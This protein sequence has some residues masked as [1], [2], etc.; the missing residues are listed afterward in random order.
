MAYI[1]S[2]DFKE[3]LYSGECDYRATLIIN[4]NT[5]PN[6]QISSISISSPIVDDTNDMFY[7]GT[8]ISQKI[9]IKFNN[10]DGLSL[11]SGQNVSLSIGQYVNNAWVDVPIGLFIVDDLGENYQK[12]CEIT[13]MDYGVKFKPNI[14]YS[15][16]FVDGKATIDT[17]L[18][19]ICTQFGVTLGDYPTIN[20]DVEIGTYDSTISGKQWISYIAEIKGCNAKIDREGRLTLQPLKQASNQV[21]DATQNASFELGEKY[22]VSKVTYTDA[23]RNYTYG[24]D[25]G[26]TLFI[27]QDNPFVSDDVVKNIYL[28]VL[29]Q[30]ISETNTNINLEDMVNNMPLEISPIYGNT[31]QE[32]I[33]A[34]KNLLVIPSF[35]NYTSNGITFSYSKGVLTYSGTATSSTAYAGDKTSFVLPPNRYTFST[36]QI[37]DGVIPQFSLYSSNT[38]STLRKVNASTKR[39]TFTSTQPY[40]AIRL[41]LSGLTSG[42]TYSGTI[43]LQLEQNTTSTEWVEPQG[44]SPTPSEP[45]KIEVVSG[46]NEIDIVGA[47]ILSMENVGSTIKNGITYTITDNVVVLNG[48]STGTC[49]IGIDLL[50]PIPSGSV[51][52]YGANN[53]EIP[54][55][56]SV[57]IRPSYNNSA[58]ETLWVNSLN[59]TRANYT[60]PNDMNK[61]YVVVENNKT[62]NNF[63]LKLMANYGTI[64]IPYEPYTS[65]KYPLNLPVENLFKNQA[66]NTT[67]QGITFTNDIEKINIIGTSSSGFYPCIIMYADGSYI[68]SDW[69]AT[70]SNINSSKGYFNNN[71]IDNIFTIVNNGTSTTTSYRYIL[72][73]E[74]TIENNSQNINASSYKILN[75]NTER[76]NFI[77]IG[78][79]PSQTYNLEIKIQ[80]E[81]GTKKNSY[82]PYGVEPIELCKMGDYQD[83][84]GHIKGI[85]LFKTDYIVNGGVTINDSTNNYFTLTN[86]WADPFVSTTNTNTILKPNTKYTISCSFKCASR[87]SSF[88]VN[89][90]NRILSLYDGTH[91]YQLIHDD[92][93]NTGVLGIWYDYSYT[94]TTPSTLNN[95]SF[96]SYTYKDT[97]NTTTGSIE[98]TNLQ[99][100]EGTQTSDFEPYGNSSE[101]YLKKEIEKTELNGSESWCVANTNNYR[102]PLGINVSNINT[103][104]DKTLILSDHFLS[105]GSSEGDVDYQYTNSFRR[106]ES[107]I[108]IWFMLTK[109]FISSTTSDAILSEWE[110]WLGTNN[111]IV[112]YI[113]ANSRYTKITNQTLL[114][115]LNALEG[116]YSYDGTTNISTT[117]N[118]LLPS[119]SVK[120]IQK[121]NFEAYSLKTYGIGDFTLDAWD[122]MSYQVD[123][124]TYKTLNS[125]TITYSGSIMGNYETKIPTKQQEITTNVVEENIKSVKKFA[126]TEIDNVN[127]QISLKVGKDEVINSI[128]LST[129]GASIDANKISLN[130]KTINLTSDTI[131]IKS[132]NFDVDTEGNLTC[133]E[134]TMKGATF[135]GGDVTLY[136][137]IN[138]NYDYPLQIYAYNTITSVILNETYDL[139][140]LMFT[141]PSS[142][143]ISSLMVDFDTPFLR[144]ENDEIKIEYY[145]FHEVFLGDNDEQE[146][147]ERIL[148]KTTNLS[149]NS[150]KLIT[151]WDKLNDRVRI[152]KQPSDIFQTME[153]T[154]I[155]TSYSYVLNIT[156][157]ALT[158]TN[159]LTKLNANTIATKDIFLRDENQQYYFNGGGTSGT[160]NTNMLINN[161]SGGFRVTNDASFYD[162]NYRDIL[163]NKVLWDG[164]T[165]GYLML[166]SQTATLSESISN[167]PH[168]IVLVWSAYS[169]GVAQNYH[170]HC[171]FIPKEFI[172]LASSRGYTSIM[173]GSKFVNIA[174]KYVYINDT[175]ITGNADNNATGTASG[176]TYTNNAYVLRYVIGV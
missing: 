158:T 28:N 65:Q 24:D 165:T 54:P 17:I 36:D 104:V 159:G 95:Y 132:N 89:N 109:Y 103:R 105:N 69:W 62:L 20:G 64:A 172:N 18:Q 19:Y 52:S 102:Y 150:N 167:Q 119:L 12:T 154:L 161:L 7:V 49:Y 125:N 60:L 46:D 22:N 118:N 123:E 173:G 21:K 145:F 147:W 100:E 87:P 112:Y 88:G 106:G 163:A 110:T 39:I 47:N 122:N 27:R 168:G 151:L 155:D 79:S 82:T 78:L 44:A 35:S 141:Y 30:E 70:A 149:N 174:T 41:G 10:L 131:N 160:I 157:Y 50:K 97:N 113:L 171:D 33:E 137:D 73:K 133:N 134:A 38:S 51:I 176:I 40:Q 81:K 117:I 80:L 74:T 108:T 58:M 127:A 76:I 94:F 146:V 170:W 32:Q 53:I 11:E 114:S 13:C 128:N 148:E 45:S 144:F 57:S 42:N 140:K 43:K 90:Q 92:R 93:K 91:L 72:G 6:E 77:A 8:F 96:I 99:I 135:T 86:K 153:C 143:Y 23:I 139:Y 115:Q 59:Q 162:S 98:I 9:T 3:K 66:F 152:S 61:F 116:A 107:N 156:K 63:T 111:V 130:G 75:A 169:G 84:I 15:P 68:T 121:N 124:N 120:G 101:W 85:N 138:D 31:Y 175:S 37:I 29:T 16:C 2:N 129:E 34:N 164:G 25:S 14:D 56:Y 126:K 67:R 26:N 142:G 166:A 71:D 83:N 4:G 1:V 55:S 48:T 5:I 136:Q